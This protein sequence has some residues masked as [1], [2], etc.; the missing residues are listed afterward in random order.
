MYTGVLL[1]KQYDPAGQ[2]Q[3]PSHKV[4]V[5]SRVNAPVFV[6]Q[7]STTKYARLVRPSLFVK[8]KGRLSDSAALPVGLDS[9]T[10][11]AETQTPL[12]SASSQMLLMAIGCSA[13]DLTDTH[14]LLDPWVSP[15]FQCL[16]AE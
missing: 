14:L 8:E 15:I 2:M 9:V 3:P 11:G 7:P 5:H 1:G 4:I 10:F 12:L 16:L 13:D 6:F